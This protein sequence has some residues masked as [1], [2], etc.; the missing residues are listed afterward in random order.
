MFYVSVIGSDTCHLEGYV[1]II[2]FDILVW[3]R[4]LH[5]YL[6]WVCCT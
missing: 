1:S 3:N 5:L 6:N 4:P 2:L